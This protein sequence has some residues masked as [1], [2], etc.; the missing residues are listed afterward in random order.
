MLLIPYGKLQEHYRGQELFGY[1]NR[2][3][4]RSFSWVK[5]T[6]NS[7]GGFPAFDSNKNDGQ[8]KF[9]TFVFWMT[10]ID[11]SA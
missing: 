1:Y 7:D 10:Q 4:K 3:I 2:E 5:S 8:Y 9:W 6:Q 11:K